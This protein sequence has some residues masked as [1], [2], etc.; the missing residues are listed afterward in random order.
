MNRFFI[1]FIKNE[2]KPNKKLTFQFKY[3]NR[4]DKLYNIK[5][6]NQGYK[7][8]QQI[9]KNN[10]KKMDQRNNVNSFEFNSPKLTIP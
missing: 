3:N 4:K 1:K 5:Y 8:Q 7:Y 2:I 10:K 6:Q 9:F